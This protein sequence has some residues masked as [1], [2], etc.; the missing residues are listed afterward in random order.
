PDGALPERPPRPSGAQG[1]RLHTRPGAECADQHGHR[2][3]RQRLS[4]GSRSRRGRRRPMT[5]VFALLLAGG[6]A[7]AA[8]SGWT[9]FRGPN[10]SGVDSAAGYPVE[11]S[12]TKN[13]LWKKPV[14]FGQSSPVVAGGRVY[15]T[16][17]DGDR[18]LTICLDAKTGRELWKRDTRRTH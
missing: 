7:A 12:P 2:L 18:L 13:V 1:C 16:A 6:I 11:F 17:S 14:P 10:G 9:Q 4:L 3:V 15:V 5:K 8:D